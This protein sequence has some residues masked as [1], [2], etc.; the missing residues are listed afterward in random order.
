MKKYHAI[1]T[2]EKARRLWASIRAALLDRSA[3]PDRSIT[4]PV[5]FPEF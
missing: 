3:D 1:V 2:R 5:Y 4:F